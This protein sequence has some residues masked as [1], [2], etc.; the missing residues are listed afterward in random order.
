M[1]EQATYSE[2][3]APVGDRI[4]FVLVARDEPPPLLE[5][6]IHDL[7]QT[8]EGHAREI[9]IVDDGS[10]VPVSLES[11]D[12]NVVRNSVPICTARARRYGVAI[13]SGNILVS[14]DAHMRFAPEWLDRMLAHVESGALLCATW[15]DY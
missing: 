4:S 5:R 12:V 1:P 9:V 2:T 11:P 7:L 6:T 3:S 8:S 13:S 15:W 14:M 10:F